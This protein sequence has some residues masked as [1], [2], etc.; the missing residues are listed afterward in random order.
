MPP[1]Q[2]GAGLPRALKSVLSPPPA[3]M[4]PGNSGSPRLSGT[5]QTTLKVT[6]VN[7]GPEAVVEARC[8]LPRRF[9]HCASP[10]SNV[11]GQVPLPLQGELPAPMARNPA[12]QGQDS[13]VF[14]THLLRKDQ[15]TCPWARP[16]LPSGVGTPEPQ[17]ACTDWLKSLL[18]PCFQI[19]AGS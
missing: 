14:T 7:R 9:A 18:D 16:T 17:A 11:P 3:P 12:P 4:S 15:P 13:F 19:R 5:L 8:A 6:D 2:V 1:A 10:K